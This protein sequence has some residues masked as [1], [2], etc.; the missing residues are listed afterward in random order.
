MGF[1]KVAD[2]PFDVAEWKQLSHVHRIRPLVMRW[3]EYGTDSPGVVHLF[4]IVKIAIYC[5]GSKFGAL[6]ST[7]A[8]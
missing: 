7:A 4:Y 3:V 1:L 5:W 8:G 6:V 2:P